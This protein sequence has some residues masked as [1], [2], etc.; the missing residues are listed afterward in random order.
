MRMSAKEPKAGDSPPH[1]TLGYIGVDTQHD[2]LHSCV[3]DEGSLRMDKKKISAPKSSRLIYDPK[4]ILLL[5]LL[6]KAFHLSIMPEIKS[7]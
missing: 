2:V 7:L 6:G 5:V 1:L 4:V 3:M